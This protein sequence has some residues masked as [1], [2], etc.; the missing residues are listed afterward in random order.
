[1]NDFEKLIN[2][3]LN[4]TIINKKENRRIKR[5]AQRSYKFFKK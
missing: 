2:D 5:R 4:K 1:M 3:L